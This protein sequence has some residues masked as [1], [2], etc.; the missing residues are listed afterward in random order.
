MDSGHGVAPA[1]IDRLFDPFFT[2]K[3]HGT[4]LGLPVAHQIVRQMGGSLLAQANPGSGNDVLGSPPVEGSKLM[5]SAR[6]LVVDD[7]DNLRWVLQTQLEQMGYAVITAADGPTAL[8]LIDKEPPALVLTDLK[9]PGMSG[10]ELLEQIRRDYPEI[11]VL[12]IT[13]FGTIQ[14][15]VQAMRSG[16]YDYLTK[17]IDYDELGIAVSRVLEHFRLVQE[18]RSLRASLDR[19]YGFENIIGHSEALLSV[20]DTAVRAA[21]SNS[22][23]LIHAETGTGKELLAKAIHFNSRRK[24][25]AVR[26]DQLRRYSARSAG[27]RAVRPREGIVHGRH[28]AQ[29][30]EGR[31]GGSGDPV[32][33]RN[34]RD[35][36]RA[37]S[38]AAA[39]ATAG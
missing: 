25:K 28:G 20:L 7:D 27:I 36:G 12:I 1:H 33:R 11:P 13:A 14:S 5:N 23:I 29:D 24:D 15:A 8:G 38:E 21:Q 39:A 32:P 6:I 10:M 35:A 34:R 4:G 22:T 19:K 9:M 31:I 26:H 16:A 37:S 2:T 30:R 3:E 17:P 18:V